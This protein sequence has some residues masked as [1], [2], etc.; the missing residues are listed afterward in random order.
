MTSKATTETGLS[1]KN[2]RRDIENGQGD[3][4]VG[5]DCLETTKTIT[6]NTGSCEGLPAQEI[7]FPDGGIRA[8]GVVFG[9]Y[10]SGVIFYENAGMLTTRCAG[11][12]RSFVVTGEH[13]RI[14]SSQRG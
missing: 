6:A 3:V 14:S 2:V 5:R 8:W 12:W 1:E 13:D 7:T 9:A 10:V 11:F 4:G